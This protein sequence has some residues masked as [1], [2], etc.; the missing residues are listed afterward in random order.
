MISHG[1]YFSSPTLL[2]NKISGGPI[3]SVQE[4]GE[5]LQICVVN[6]GMG[7]K[8]AL[9]ALPFKCI[10]SLESQHTI[11]FCG[12]LQTQ[13]MTMFSAVFAR[14]SF[15]VKWIA[16]TVCMEVSVGEFFFL[17]DPPQSLHVRR[18]N[19]HHA[20]QPQLISHHPSGRHANHH[21]TS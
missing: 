5:T 10:L 21:H 11:D 15:T 20:S 18:T 9:Y 1:C 3:V 16:D 8:F 7:G 14:V 17:T 6:Y 4:S 19:H 2:Q 13:H 12:R